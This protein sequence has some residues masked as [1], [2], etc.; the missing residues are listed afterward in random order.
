MSFNEKKSMY[1]LSPESLMSELRFGIAM[2]TL[3]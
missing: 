3:R 1:Q 2:H